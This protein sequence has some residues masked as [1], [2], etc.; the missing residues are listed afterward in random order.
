MTDMVRY[1]VV[2]LVLLAL[3]MRVPVTSRA[4]EA[5]PLPA[6]EAIAT[7]VSPSTGITT[8]VLAEIR[9][10]AA[11]IPASPAI[12]DVWLATLAPGEAIAF[13]T[14]ASPPSIVAD[15]VLGGELIVRSA[16]RVLVQRAAGLEEVA[17]NTMVTIHPDEAI[18]YVDNRAAQSFRNPGRGTLTALS[19]GVFSAAPPSTFTAGAVGQADWARSGLAGRDLTVAVER[20]TVPPGA[21]LPA[22]VP[23]VRAPR[24]FVVAQGVARSVVTTPTGAA[25]PTA[26]RFGPG[27]V[28]GFRTLDAGERLQVRNAGVRSLGLLRVTLGADPAATLVAGPPP[29]SEVARHGAWDG[30]RARRRPTP[31]GAATRVVSRR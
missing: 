15:I 23:D 9:L 7:P 26:E 29:T 2:V 30:A 24:V 21:R 1:A 22:F 13:E 18:I 5:S 3:L 10:P 25:L 27:Q 8:E 17:P 11:A 28:I 16:G 4:Q 14:G 20:L 6:G 19:V 12:V 31:R